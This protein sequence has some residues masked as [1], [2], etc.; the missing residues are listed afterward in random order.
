M[1]P[2]EIW[3]AGF[4]NGLGWWLLPYFQL[5]FR[6]GVSVIAILCLPFRCI[7]GTG[8][9]PCFTD[10]VECFPR[11]GGDQ[12]PPH[13][14][15]NG[16]HDENSDFELILWWMEAF[17]DFRLGGW[18]LSGTSMDLWEPEGKRWSEKDDPS[19]MPASWSPELVNTLYSQW[20]TVLHYIILHI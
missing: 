9:S 4:Q 20:N 3:L 1:K 6:A 12:S 19:R 7:S 5:P 17:E 11:L 16:W 13:P 18:P 2:N 14:R 15:L 8:N 10:A